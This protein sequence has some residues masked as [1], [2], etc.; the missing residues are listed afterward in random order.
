MES[1]W[2]ER[3]DNGVP[4]SLKPYPRETMID[5]LRR[6]M[7]LRPD[8]SA[9]LFKGAALT[10]R[11]LDRLSD[12]FAAW[13]V[14]DGLKKGGRV[15]CILPNSPQMLV[16]QYGVWKAGGIFAPL[17]PLYTEH[18]LVDILRLSG[19][20]TLVVLTPYYTRVKHLQ[21]QTSLRRVVATNIKEYL[22]PILRILF[23]LLKERK[24]GHHATLEGQDVWLQDTLKQGAGLP[25]PAV[26]VSPEDEAVILCSGGTTGAPKGAVGLHSGLC[27]AGRQ[28]KA[29]FGD[30]LIDWQDTFMLPLPLFHVYGMAGVQTAAMV[31]GHPLSLV[32]NP[33]DID[34]LVNT[35]QKVQPALFTGVPTLYIAL[36]N[37]PKV[38][39]GNVNFRSIKACMSGAAPLLAE[40]RRAFETLTGGRILEGY[41]LTE[42]MMACVIGPVK[43]KDKVGSIGLPLPDVEIRLVDV[44][45]G[46]RDVAIGEVG[47]L[48]LRA[49]QLMAG[50][51][52]NPAETEASLRVHGDGGPWLHTG[53]LAT[54]DEEHYISIVD[55]KKDLIKVSGYQVWPREIEEVIASHP[56][57]VEVGV[58]AIPDARKGETPKA[59]VVL[60][61]GSTTTAQE[62]REFCKANLAPYK[63]PSE[64]EIRDE[65]PKTLVGKVLRRQLRSEE[66]DRLDES[67][68]VLE[69][70]DA[71]GVSV[72][73]GN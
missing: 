53:D 19:A 46:Q 72:T 66:L 59:W 57:V 12:A 45:S 8:A 49:P 6:N 52:K 5:L 22:P 68:N 30:T 67:G 69:T 4:R 31:G 62:L 35:I 3:Y 23:T 54:I 11:Q 64:F 24:E 42:A 55:R 29:W 41:S 50:Y 38:A 44:E 33:R 32:P 13:L 56:S 1:V 25:P 48:I 15:A 70:A 28:L 61:K 26:T 34:D 63:T 37:H 60:R 39:A 40:T 14:K 18:E 7:R 71:A 21:A 51:W 36:L 20:E 16:V 65:L 10:Y 2:S 73:E 17:N 47:E 27:A 43:G 58:A 9:A